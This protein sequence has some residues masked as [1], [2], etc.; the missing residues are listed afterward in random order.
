[1]SRSWNIPYK[2]GQRVLHAIPDMET[3]CEIVY[4]GS[5]YVTL[6]SLENPNW[7]FRCYEA[8]IDNLLTAI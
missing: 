2:M 8:E 6:Q 4:V 3:P 1:M 5:N 7:R